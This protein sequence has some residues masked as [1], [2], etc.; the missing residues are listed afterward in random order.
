MMKVSL[1]KKHYTPPNI[2]PYAEDACMPRM[3]LTRLLAL[4][5]WSA[6]PEA[7]SICLT[8][9]PL[10]VLLALQDEKLCSNSVLEVPLVQILAHP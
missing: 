3:P 2:H 10:P 6:Q 1:T 7:I 4:D 8:S 9:A 5:Y